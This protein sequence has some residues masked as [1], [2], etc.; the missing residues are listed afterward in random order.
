[1]KRRGAAE[2]GGRG[3]WGRA[4]CVA[5]AGRHGRRE[6]N[7]GECGDR[8]PAWPGTTCVRV[9]RGKG[10]RRRVV[11]TDRLPAKRRAW[12]APGVDLSRH[13][14]GMC[15]DFETDATTIHARWTLISDRWR[16]PHAGHRRQLDHA[17][18]TRGPLGLGEHRAS[19]GCRRRP[20]SL[21][22]C[23]RAGAP[24]AFTCRSTTASRRWRSAWRPTP[25]SGRSA[26][27]RGRLSSTAP[28]LSRAAAPRPGSPT[29][30]SLAGAWSG[31]RSISAYSGNAAD[32]A[33]SGGAAGGIAAGCFVIDCAPNMGAEMV[34]ERTE[35]L[36]RTIRRA[37]PETPVV[38]VEDRTFCGTP[39]RC[40]APQGHAAR[41][42][43]CANV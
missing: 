36:V 25:S 6:A 3:L 28:P 18:V 5:I 13:S 38:L 7:D 26:A 12:F 20:C 1:M 23:A 27:P 4:G 11:L 35:P 16:C 14:A 34:A 39:L 21:A 10:G 17:R 32:G 43:R 22:G 19:E 15:F 24:I 40:R 33:G 9:L 2:A 29:R 42:G 37:H 30:R 31:R 41:R 8:R